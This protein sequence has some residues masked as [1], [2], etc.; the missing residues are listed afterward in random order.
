MA[1]N[2]GTRGVIGSSLPGMAS[3]IERGVAGPPG[4]AGQKNRDGEMSG[5]GYMDPS[6]WQ[7]HAQQLAQLRSAFQIDDWHM[8]WE[9]HIDVTKKFAMKAE[10]AG[11]KES[12]AISGKTGRNWGWNTDHTYRLKRIFGD[13]WDG[14]ECDKTF[15][16]TNPDMEFFPGG[17]G[18]KKLKKREY[19]L[20]IVYKKLGLKRGGWGRKKEWKVR[21]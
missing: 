4:S 15:M 16:D 3:A 9:G 18:Q 20:S 11:V 8:L 6:K 5:K 12:V 7:A 14:T 13:T 19:D 10:D 1:G 2:P 17:R 21:E